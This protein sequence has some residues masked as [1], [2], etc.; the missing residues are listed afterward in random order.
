MKQ[1]EVLLVVVAS[2]FLFVPWMVK[3]EQFLE[4]GNFLGSRKINATEAET[5]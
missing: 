3:H 5:F 2:I 4:P 1:W